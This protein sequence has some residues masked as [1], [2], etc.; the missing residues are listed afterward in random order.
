[1]DGQ[2]I[3]EALQAAIN[4]A[5]SDAGAKLEPGT[6][7][8][9]YQK[10]GIAGHEINA[11]LEEW[12]EDGRERAVEDGRSAYRTF[13]AEMVNFARLVQAFPNLNEQALDSAMMRKG[14]NPPFW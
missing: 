4:G 7:E 5:V 8:K 1:M 11:H 6:R 10:A 12:D 2:E 9:L 13:V 14:P 3:R